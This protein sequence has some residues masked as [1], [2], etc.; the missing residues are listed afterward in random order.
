MLDQVNGEYVV[1]RRLAAMAKAYGFDGWLLNIEAEFPYA[2]QHPIS[3]LSA[4]IRSLKRSLEPHGII[5]WYDAITKNNE[6]DYQN[7]L[8]WRNVEFALAADAMFTN[9]KWTE[10]ELNETR[11]V[12]EQHG[13]KPAETYFGIDV[14]AQNTN[15]PGPPRVTYPPKGGGGTLTG[16]VCWQLNTVRQ[17]A[18]ADIVMQAT[19]VL[20]GNGFSA[21]IFAPGWPYEHFSKSVEAPGSRRKPLGSEVEAP[22][23]ELKRSE[24]EAEAVERSMWEGKPLPEG[25]ECSCKKGQPHDRGGYK[26]HPILNTAREYPAGS[27]SFL[28]TDFQQAFARSLHKSTWSPKLGSQAILPRVSPQPKSEVSEPILYSELQDSPNPHLL[29]GVKPS[30]TSGNEPDNSITG[31]ENVIG[32]KHTTLR[33]C[34][35]KTDIATHSEL[36]AAV[37]YKR[38]HSSGGT[39]SMGFYTAF[40]P[41]DSDDIG[42]ANYKISPD[43]S[44]KEQTKLFA[45]DSMGRNARIV[46]FGIYSISILNTAHSSGLL[47]LYNL[48]IRPRRAAG[49]IW[50]IRDLKMVQRRAGPNSERRLTWKWDGTKEHWPVDLPWSNTTGPFSVFTIMMGDEELGQAHCTEFP[51]RPGDH[52][53]QSEG[54]ASIDLTVKG[55]LFGGDWVSSSCVAVPWK[56]LFVCNS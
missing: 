48:R 14:W 46:E 35:F 29:V 53:C 24:S 16:V 55:R 30:R 32:H 42:Y 50:S 6:V 23:S 19:N 34:L 37:S 9:Y 26:T 21:A 3:K 22:E 12:A 39:L 44:H 33:L 8:T 5:V 1:A 7:A 36:E 4:F 56:E 13:I 41:E 43:G 27:A 49:K 54:G 45:L 2:V 51:I 52:V 10:Y 15:M 18:I 25:L 31:A 11:S 47:A 17:C 20:A 28:E 40:L 38:S